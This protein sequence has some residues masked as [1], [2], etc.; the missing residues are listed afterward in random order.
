MACF[1]H[2]ATPPLHDRTAHVH[3]EKADT[4][5]WDTQDYP[6]GAR[7]QAGTD[8]VPHCLYNILQDPY[9]RSELAQA[10]NNPSPRSNVTAALKRLLAAY[11][12]VGTEAGMPNINDVDWNEQGTPYDPAACMVAVRT[13][14]W[15]PWLPS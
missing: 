14:Y 1:V 5:S 7:S 4:L 2:A 9:E 13:G 11:T 10:A 6:C 3:Y 8:C 15:S 12:R